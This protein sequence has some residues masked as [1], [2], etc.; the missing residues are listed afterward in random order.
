MIAKSEAI[1]RFAGFGVPQDMV[2]GIARRRRGDRCT[3]AAR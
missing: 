1:A 2:D 3:S